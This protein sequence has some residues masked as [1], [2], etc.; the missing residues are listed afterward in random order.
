M[1][2]VWRRHLSCV[3][4]GISNDRLV[5]SVGLQ[6]LAILSSPMHLLLDM[7]IAIN[8]AYEVSADL[9]IF[10]TSCFVNTYGFSSI[11]IKAGNILQVLAG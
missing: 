6:I 2:S 9:F 5:L 11:L 10:F 3:R 7:D 4:A 8:A 1:R